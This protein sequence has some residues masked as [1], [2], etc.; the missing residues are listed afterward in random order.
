MRIRWLCGI[1]PIGLAVAI[2]SPIDAM[3]FTSKTLTV[4]GEYPTIQA[5]LNA[6]S[7][8]DTVAVSPGTYPENIDFQSKAVS[9]VS[10]GGASHTTI[11][12]AGSIVGF[13]ISGGTADFG[14]G[15]AVS[16]SGTV[17]AKD[18]FQSNQEGSGGFGA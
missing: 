17:I 18:I 11:A 12:P 9:V 10:T 8:G 14:A 4:P 6:A 3:A 1:L 13:T 2:L 5:A 15:M 16:G 7:S